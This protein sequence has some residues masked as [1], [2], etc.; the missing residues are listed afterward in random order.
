MGFAV[1]FVAG[2]TGAN[3]EMGTTPRT[4]VWVMRVVVTLFSE[5]KTQMVNGLLLYG[6]NRTTCCKRN[7]CSL[8][9]MCHYQL[10]EMIININPKINQN[11]Q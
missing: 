2:V 6:N 10:A 7:V 1:F 5:S 3:L 11:L 9:Y 4:K 8:Q